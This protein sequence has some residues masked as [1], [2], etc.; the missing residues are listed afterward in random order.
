MATHQKLLDQI[1][2]WDEYSFPKTGMKIVRKC[3]LML[4][5]EYGYIKAVT[6]L[7]R[8]GMD[9]CSLSEMMRDIIRNQE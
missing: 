2:G 9:E 5:K 7:L 4:D 6:L 1:S 8:A 3:F